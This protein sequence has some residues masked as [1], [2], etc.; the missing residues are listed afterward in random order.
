MAPQIPTEKDDFAKGLQ[1]AYYEGEWNNIP[2]FS[3]L[4]TVKTGIMQTLN[5]STVAHRED[6]FGLVI[7]GFIEIP[8]Q[9]SVLFISTQMM[10]QNYIS[11]MNCS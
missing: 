3:K 5:L 9:V 11:M 4:Q 6:H 10:A 7:E 1:Y 8:K 2:D